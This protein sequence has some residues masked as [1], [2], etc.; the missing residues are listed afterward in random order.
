MTIKKSV[1]HIDTVFCLA[2]QYILYS[3][4]PILAPP[5]PYNRYI[6]CSIGPIL[7]NNEI[8]TKI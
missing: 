6:Y 1:Q 2:P 7:P 3:V 4:Y 8:F 5:L